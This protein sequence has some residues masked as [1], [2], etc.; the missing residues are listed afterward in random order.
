MTDKATPEPQHGPARQ[1][2]IRL[3]TTVFVVL[4]VSMLIVGT[5]LVLTQ[6]VGVIGLNAD[7]VTAAES[8]VSPIAFGIAAVLGIWTLLLSYAHGW[9]PSEG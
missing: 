3:M 9:K 2:L 4:L 8:V 1:R 5:V 6:L 7:L